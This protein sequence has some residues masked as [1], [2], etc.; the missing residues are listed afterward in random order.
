MFGC[1]RFG[2]FALGMGYGV[3]LGIDNMNTM[4]VY[5]TGH[6][7]QCNTDEDSVVLKLGLCPGARVITL[8]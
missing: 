2:L 5:K 1:F 6:T 3:G 4:D 7:G 8:K